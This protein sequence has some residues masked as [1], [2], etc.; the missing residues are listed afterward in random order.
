MMPNEKIA[1]FS[2]APPLNKLNNAATLPPDFSLSALR[3]HSWITAWLTPGVVIAAPNRTMTMIASVNRMRR[4]S[5]GILTV[6]KNAETIAYDLPVNRKALA[7]PRFFL[8]RRGFRGR[9]FLR[10]G[11]LRRFR[12]GRCFRLLRRV[13]RRGLLGIARAL[14]SFLPQRHTAPGLFDFFPRRRADLVRLDRD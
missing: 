6:F 9:L 11:L 3:N 13:A 1:Q 14:H 4:R 10:D 5:S 2:S 8:F 12:L 7:L